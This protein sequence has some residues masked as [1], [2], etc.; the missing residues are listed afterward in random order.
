MKNLS[1]NISDM[2]L[3]SRRSAPSGNSRANNP[4]LENFSNYNQMMI[5]Q[6]QQQQQQQQLQQQQQQQRGFQRQASELQTP[7]VSMMSSE[8]NSKRNNLNKF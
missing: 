6:Q 1:S 7:E 2:K 4:H 3:D 8:T 5:L